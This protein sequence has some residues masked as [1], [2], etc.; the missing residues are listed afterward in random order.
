MSGY[1]EYKFD[2]QFPESEIPYWS[3]Q[4]GCP[5]E[6]TFLADIYEGVKASGYYSVDDFRALCKW[7][8]PRSQ[9]LIARNSESDITALTRRALAVNGEALRIEILT[10]LAGVSWPTASVLLHVGTGYRY[11]IIDNRAMWSL[12]YE[13]SPAHTLDFWLA[14]TSFCRKA[15]ERNSITL[16]TLDRSLW[17]YAKA[18]QRSSTAIVAMKVPVQLKAV[19]GRPA[20]AVGV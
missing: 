3:D 1:S 4:D 5:E 11:P 15:A 20:E 18:N 8:T 6:D 2:T 19:V 7:R 16:R 12:G 13:K 17:A 9:T 10:S 14:Y